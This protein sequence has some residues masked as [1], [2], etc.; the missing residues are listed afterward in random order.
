MSV[1]AS[2]GANPGAI[3]VDG[4][5]LDVQRTGKYFVLSV[6]APGITERTRPGQFVTVGMG[7]E[8]SSMI[9]RRSFAIQRVQARG[10]YGGTL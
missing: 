10:M 2:V 1:G 8:E 7:G 6:T 5:V 9:L 4:E 3:Q